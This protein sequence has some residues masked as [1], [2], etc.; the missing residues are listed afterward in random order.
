MK[1]VS[2]LGPVKK[3]E[4]TFSRCSALE[5]VTLGVGIKTIKENAFN[6]C[7]SLKTIYVPAKKVDYYKERLPESLHSLIVELPAE[8]K[9]KKK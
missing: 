2:I 1:S 7:T 6:F 5:T 4:E 9:A 8:K 3:L